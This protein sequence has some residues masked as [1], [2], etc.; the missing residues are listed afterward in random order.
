MSTRRNFLKYVGFF[1]ATTAMGV[2]LG[3]KGAERF[4]GEITDQIALLKLSPEVR[5]MVDEIR[6]YR[7]SLGLDTLPAELTS[8]LSRPKEWGKIDSKF[9]VKD[10]PSTNLS[11]GLR[12]EEVVTCLFGKNGLRNICGAKRDPNYPEGMSFDPADRNCNISDGVHSV[13]IEDDFTD[14][15]LHEAIGHGSDP[16]I[17]AIYPLAILIKIEHGKWRALSQS[18]KVPGQ[19]LD[20]PDDL[21]FPLL[22]KYVG[23]AIAYFLLNPDNSPTFDSSSSV[24][25]LKEELLKIAEN[26][27]INLESLRF[28]KSVCKKIGE[29]MLGKQITGEIKFSGELKKVYQERMDHICREIYA[30]MV[31]YAL[32]YPDHIK[33]N[34]EV[35]GGIHE[36]IEAVNGF[37]IDIKNIENVIS[38]PKGEIIAANKLELGLIERFKKESVLPQEGEEQK[39]KEEQ[40]AREEQK[41]KEKAENDFNSFSNNGLWPQSLEI[42]ESQLDDFRK[43]AQIYKQIIGNYPILRDTFGQQYDENFDPNLHIWEIREIENAIDSGFVRSILAKRKLENETMQEIIKRTKILEKFVNNP[44]FIPSE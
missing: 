12:I 42:E 14:Y 41:A 10:L 39:A 11:Y 20:H 2:V 19:F 8:D 35:I 9:S 40:K 17:G 33:N 13:S 29:T 25:V 7:Q 4:G 43:F 34:L 18:L 38:R 5:K 22:K 6:A 3:V 44:A 28:N 1:S 31:K 24:N 30:E 21:M 16:S 15:V 37:P 23:E 26:N 32:K 36:I 27:G